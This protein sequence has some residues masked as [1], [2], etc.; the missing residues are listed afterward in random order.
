MNVRGFSGDKVNYFINGIPMNEPEDRVMNWS[1]WSGLS[2]LIAAIQVVR[3]PMFIANSTGAF[4]GAVQFETRKVV[5]HKKTR[6]RSS[7]GFFPTSGRV[8]DG[9]GVFVNPK[10]GT[11]YVF[12][13]ERHTGPIWRDRV[14]ISMILEQK[15]GDSYIQGTTYDG[16]ALAL[17]ATGRFGRHA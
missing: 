11:H 17:N 2:S 9:T 3:G 12:S 5:P 15:Q 16:Y 6:L 8:A 4:G 1:D 10:A 13:F 14:N 7:V